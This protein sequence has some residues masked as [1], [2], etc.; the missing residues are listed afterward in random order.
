MKQS[1][2]EHFSIKNEDIKVM[3]E[4]F[5]RTLKSRMWQ[6]FSHRH[7]HRYIN[8]LHDSLNAFPHSS[9]KGLTPQ[10]ARDHSTSD[11]LWDIQY[12]DMPLHRKKKKRWEPNLSPGDRVRI[13]HLNKPF[14]KYVTRTGVYYISDAEGEE[15]EGSFY[16]DEL[17]KV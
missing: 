14:D 6:Y 16:E 15:I 3:V 8:V 12:E 5:N 13:V 11:E 9:L 4:R 10:Y 7:T 2:I 17:Q 1:R